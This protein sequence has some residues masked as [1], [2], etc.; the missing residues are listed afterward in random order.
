MNR[1]TDRT[2]L[3]VEGARAV[4]TGRAPPFLTLDDANASASPP[5]GLS[6]SSDTATRGRTPWAVA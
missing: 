4:V 6:P 3:T 5:A 1:F 2:V